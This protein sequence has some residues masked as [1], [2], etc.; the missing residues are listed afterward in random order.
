MAGRSPRASLTGYGSPGKF[1]AGMTFWV[2]VNNEPRNRGPATT[3]HVSVL[4]STDYELAKPPVPPPTR[5]QRHRHGHP[6]HHRY[7]LVVPPPSL[8]GRP[9]RQRCGP[10]ATPVCLPWGPA[11]MGDTPGP[12]RSLAGKTSSRTAGKAQQRYAPRPTSLLLVG[13]APCVVFPRKARTI[14]KMSPKISQLRFG[15]RLLI[16]AVSTTC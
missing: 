2:A 7:I 13:R 5:G 8:T 4:S 15:R 3:A 6:S 12:L 10:G 14:G 11:P 9:V 1:V 16:L